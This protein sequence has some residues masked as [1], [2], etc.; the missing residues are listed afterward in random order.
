MTKNKLSNNQSGVIHH[1]ALFVLIGLVLAGVSF[2]GWRVWQGRSEASATNKWQQIV[3]NSHGTVSA[4]KSDVGGSWRVK[5]RV[6]AKSSNV[7]GWIQLFDQKGTGASAQIKSTM[8]VEKLG[9][10]AV[11]KGKSYISPAKTV[12][13]SN[14]MIILVDMGVP[15]N[16]FA[17]HSES[18]KVS[19]I[20]TKCS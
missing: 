10:N 12:S 9:S 16:E 2:A 20:T 11:K 18:V 7:S 3:S 14:T 6:A 4:C 15:S 17:I 19:S 13:K 8:L 1:L 5:A